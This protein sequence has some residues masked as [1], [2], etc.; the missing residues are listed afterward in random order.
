MF[1]IQDIVVFLKDESGDKMSGEFQF[2]ID[3]FV[4]EVFL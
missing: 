3:T 1:Y 2:L 4:D